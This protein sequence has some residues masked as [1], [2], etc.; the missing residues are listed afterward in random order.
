MRHSPLRAYE[1]WSW[2]PIASSGIQIIQN[3]IT[4]NTKEP[5]PAPST[6]PNASETTPINTMKPKTEPIMT[7]AVNSPTPRSYLGFEMLK[8]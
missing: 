4:A 5:Q 3:N 8:P 2:A 7:P 1:L 6:Q